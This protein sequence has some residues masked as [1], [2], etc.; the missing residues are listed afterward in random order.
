MVSLEEMWKWID[1]YKYSHA[2]EV[3]LLFEIDGHLESFHSPLLEALL[4]VFLIVGL[5]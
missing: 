3:G 4:I 2:S 5:Q 1:I